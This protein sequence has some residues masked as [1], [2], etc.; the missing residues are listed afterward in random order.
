L[1]LAVQNERLTRLVGSIVII[2]LVGSVALAL[3]L[4]GCHWRSGI[5][6]TVYFEHTPLRTGGEVQVAGK[7]IGEVEDV[8]LVPRELATGNHPL[9]GTGGVALR[10]WIDARYAERAAINGEYF[11]NAKGILGQPYLEVG[12]PADSA[13]WERPV[14]DG[15]AIRG[16]DPPRVDRVLMRSYENLMATSL[17]MEAVRPAG[18]ELMRELRELFVTLDAL[19]PNAESFDELGDSIDELITEATAV[20]DKFASVDVGFDDIRSLAA[21]ARRTFDLADRRIGEI[22][23]K[24]ALLSTEIDRLGDQIPTDL[25]DRFRAIASEADVH[26]AKVQH[27]MATVRELQA[28]LERGE[29]TIG[30]LANDPEFSDDA[31]KLG[32]YIKRHPWVVVGVPRDDP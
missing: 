3:G 1:G 10:L 5:T 9:A 31:K 4:Q 28:M 32:K 15:D 16:I 22:R 18:K 7:V 11:I 14:R 6:V 8:G 25:G 29:G 13:L 19:E 12:P 2:L 17:F 24:I 23:T 21:K 20:Q 26:L 27:T 30:A